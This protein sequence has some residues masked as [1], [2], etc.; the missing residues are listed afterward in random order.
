M[1]RRLR[2]L[3]AA[4]GIAALAWLLLATLERGLAL[5]QRF[6]T[7]PEG[8]RWLIGLLLTAI[9]LAG[10]GVGIWWLRPRKPRPPV[11]APDRPTL[12]TRLTKLR[13]SGADVE[14][15][16]SELDELDRRRDL[17]ELHVAVFGEISTGKSTLIAALVPGAQLQ[18]DPR[19]GTTRVVAHYDGV[20]PDGTTWTVADVPG[21]AEAGGE[22]RERMA[23]EEVLRAHAVIYVCSGDLTRAQASELQWLGDFGKP[24]VL[25]AN[26]ADQW[27][28]QERIQIEHRLRATAEHIPDAVV[29]V[30]AGGEER[31]TRRLAN[32]T[33][34]DVRRQRKPEIDALT[35]A[36]RRLVAAGATALEP[37]REN[38]VLAG[39]HERTSVLETAQRATEAQRI[40]S[41]YARRAIVGAMAAVA[42]GTDLVIQGALAAGLARALADLYGVKVTEVEIEALLRQVR[43][44]LRTGT[45]VVLAVAGNAL[46][47]FPGLGTLGGGVLHAFAYA[48]VFDSLGKA[49][50]TT[51]AERQQLD[52]AE[53]GERM[54][55]LLDDTRGNRLRH[56]AELT[57]DALRD[58]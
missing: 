16:R 10:L 54:R 58:R 11:Q 55:A 5:A 31:F 50:A 33:T 17:G 46:K 28:A 4:I 1:S 51:L 14:E 49:L 23:R 41:R 22:A 43:M 47:A 3:T 19:G 32:G 52:Q 27:N 36:L 38:A 20:A 18:S 13:E 53:A 2:M 57:T 8:L 9:L 44:T 35:A 15:L 37:A 12:E 25:A 7:L 30:S 6:M 29:L 34:E 48:L 42:P 39:L 56:L 24:L 45:S 21:S 40:V 26:K